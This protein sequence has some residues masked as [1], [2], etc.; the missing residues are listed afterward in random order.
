VRTERLLVGDDVSAVRNDVY[1]LTAEGVPL[2][3]HQ[4]FSNDWPGY[5]ALRDYL[6]S[7]LQHTGAT[8]L[9]FAGEATG[10]YWFHTFYALAQD[11]QLAAALPDHPEALRLHLYN[12]R[13]THAFKQALGSLEHSDPVDAQAIAARLR[14][15]GAPYP[16]VLDAEWLGRRLLTRHYAHLTR[17]LASEKTYFSA[18][19][20]LQASAYRQLKPFSDVFG[21]TSS[22]ILT[23]ASSLRE[24]AELPTRQLA[25]LLQTL[26]GNHLRTPDE[27]AHK[28]QAV[29]AHSFPVPAAMQAP[30]QTLLHSTLAHIQFLE[31]E[32][33]T[34]K[35]Q[36]LEA[37]APLPEYA[38][39][40]SI[41]GWGGG[42]VYP[43][44]VLA[45]ISPWQRFLYGT[46]FDR[47]Q[48]RERRKNARDAE[49]AL[50][51]W[52]GLWWPAN[53]SGGFD[54]E[55]TRLSKEGNHY[56]RYDLIEG[57][58]CVKEHSAEYASYY[59][60][61]YAESKR[62]AHQRALVLSARKLVGLV[63]ALLYTGQPYR[64]PEAYRD[65]LSPHAA[66]QQALA[67]PAL[68]P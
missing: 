51:K 21:T 5:V 59:R 30:L 32:R 40:S 46:I 18:F 3:G 64:I 50:A 58:N 20:F 44:G 13:A 63:V 67:A 4:P 16:P 56:L 61:K 62:H 28:L 8:Q 27:N 24:L 7:A 12:P 22:A 37:F 38:V 29:A 60:H 17:A 19:L 45:E 43:A 11:P 41:P 1:C 48:K 31:T 35:A 2:Q 57:V 68:A 6:V 66:R 39:L 9:D 14:F 42:S 10:W 54:G 55:I 15:A 53:Q 49:A 36:V 65:Q 34:L 33:A 25:G 23:R 47:R 26:S 52:A